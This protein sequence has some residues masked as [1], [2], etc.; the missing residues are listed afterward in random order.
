MKKKNPPPRFSDEQQPP[1]PPPPPPLAPSSHGTELSL[2]PH[3]PSGQG[4]GL[5]GG[6]GLDRTLFPI[7]LAPRAVEGARSLR[8]RGYTR[9]VSHAPSPPGE[10]R[11][12]SEYMVPHALRQLAS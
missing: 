8:H 10:G 11:R 5:S 3:L 7:P 4:T 9:R 1:L 6:G 12:G 2:A